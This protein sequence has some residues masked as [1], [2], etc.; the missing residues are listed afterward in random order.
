MN[1]KYC[2]TNTIFF[3][4]FGTSEF[5][6]SQISLPAAENKRSEAQLVGCTLSI[7]FNTMRIFRLNTFEMLDDYCLPTCQSITTS[8]ISWRNGLQKRPSKFTASEN[9]IHTNMTKKIAA[10]SCSSTSG[11]KTRES[12]GKTFGTY[13]EALRSRRLVW[14]SSL[15][16]ES[17]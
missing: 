12:Q 2:W 16:I 5:R 10:Y 11:V 8:T 1:Q 14:F 13:Y 6:L 3:S 7:F 4:L 17:F 15:S 9:L